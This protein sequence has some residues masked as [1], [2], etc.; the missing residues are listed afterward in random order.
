M[1]N[2]LKNLKD[3]I[4]AD[5][6][7][8]AS[9]VAQL[10][11]AVYADGA[12]DQEELQLMFDINNVVSGKA[13]CPEWKELFVK[14]CTDALLA[15]ATSP[16]VV[17]ADEAANLIALIGSDGQIDEL[18][19]ALLV[20]IAK[21]ATDCDQSLTDF[22]LN[23]LKTAILADGTVD[24]AEVEMLRSVIYGSG[25]DGGASV[26]KAECDTL[27]DINNAV[28][29]NANCPEW[30]D[31]FVQACTEAYLADDNS[32]GVLDADEAADL[33]AKISSDGN[34]DETERALVNNILA[35]ATT[36]D[37]SLRDF[38]ASM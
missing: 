23:A 24:V 34:V 33:I 32:P 7:V 16:G 14:V 18:E 11:T 10:R 13:N 6:V 38:A 27:F 4:L 17:D 31:F 21:T 29:G 9:E 15:D 2:V 19:L 12:V 30:Q 28:S 26:S 8:D 22:T 1:S 35:Q 20:N 37:Q 36:V 25:G 3:A 5:G